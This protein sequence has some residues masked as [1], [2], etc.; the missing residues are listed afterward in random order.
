MWYD[1]LGSILTGAI[2][3]L[4]LSLLSLTCAIIFGLMTASAKLS[5]IAPLR[6]AATC[7]TTIIRGIPDIVLM[8]LV[9]FGGQI[10]I[11]HLAVKAGL[12]PFEFS[13]FWAGIVT[14]GFIFG[15][16]FGETFRGAFMAVPAGQIEAGIAYGLSRTRVFFRILT[17]QM[18]RFALP[19]LSNNWLVLLKSTAIVSMIGLTD[20]TWLADQAGRST[21]QPFIF[22]MIVCL[23]YMLLSY[24]SGVLLKKLEKRYSAGV[25][26]GAL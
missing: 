12:A 7:Y 18:L 20:M 13:P 8:L 6:W 4:Q 9:F 23:L 21:R 19:G 1:Y 11:N 16:Y 24:A 3:T 17:P 25:I 14:I 10:L 15:A 5:P 2:L 22:Y 26:F